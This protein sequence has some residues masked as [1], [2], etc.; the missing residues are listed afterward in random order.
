MPSQSGRRMLIM[1]G[2]A[3]HHE[4]RSMDVPGAFMRSPND[5]NHRVV[6]IQPPKSDGTVTA[7]GKVCLL[8]RSM[9]GEKSANLNWDTWRDYWVKNWGWTK[10]LS[11]P[12]MFIIHAPNKVARMEA[13]NDDFLMSTLTK[14]DL[15]RLSQP[16]IDAWQVTIQDLRPGK[17]SKKQPDQ[18]TGPLNLFNT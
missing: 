18:K 11:E 15:D 3:E 16:F 5:P 14:A 1:A 9:P 12:S 2:V 17:Q 13:G 4:F 10:V 7:P 6:M 8:R